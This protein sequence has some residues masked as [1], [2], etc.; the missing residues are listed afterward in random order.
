MSFCSTCGSATIDGER[1]C[2]TCGTA[3]TSPVTANAPAS[4]LPYFAPEVP[5]AKDQTIAGFGWRVLG[6]LFDLILLF[7]VVY[8]PLKAGHV[9]FDV[10]AVITAVANFLYWTLMITFARGQSIGM[11][12]VGVRCVRADTRGVVDLSRASLR[13]L[14]YSA[15]LLFGSL[16]HVHTYVN[17]TALQRHTEGI[18]GAIYIALAIPHVLDL[19]WAAWDA[20]RQTLHDKVAGTVCVLVKHGAVVADVP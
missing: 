20:K 2:A 10:S 14:T 6:Y 5:K 8:L 7:I 4:G 19:L 1:Y 3:T 9:S 16:Y 18:H 12:L 11:A 13:A 17:P 15:L